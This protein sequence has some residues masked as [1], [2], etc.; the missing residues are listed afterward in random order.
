MGTFHSFACGAAIAF[1]AAL[2]RPYVGVGAGQRWRPTA[3]AAG[4]W[5]SRRRG[6]SPVRRSPPRLARVGYLSK[7]RRGGCK[8]WWLL[9]TQ[10]GH[11]EVVRTP[12]PNGACRKHNQPEMKST[13]KKT[14]TGR[15]K[16]TIAAAR[17]RLSCKLRQHT[18]D[19]RQHC[20]R[21]CFDRSRSAWAGRGRDSGD[22]RCLGNQSGMG[23]VLSPALG[24]STGCTRHMT[25]SRSASQCPSPASTMPA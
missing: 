9:M 21:F 19:G 24:R 14:T 4:L 10:T 8:S 5:N 2:A 3:V 17:Q 6:E 12:P 18:R 25:H 22:C 1:A 11:P 16:A 20:R 7:S 15:Y 13:G 23:A